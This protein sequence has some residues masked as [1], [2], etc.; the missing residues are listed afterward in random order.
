MKKFK[1]L[2]EL[3]KHDME[4]WGEQMLLGKKKKIVPT[5]I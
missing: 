5:A 2:V 3:P 1:I 4:T